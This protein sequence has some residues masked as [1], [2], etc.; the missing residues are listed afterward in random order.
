MGENTESVLK[1]FIP[2]IVK[3][4]GIFAIGAVVARLTGFLLRITIARGLGKSPYG[5]FSLGLSFLS[6]ASV[7]SV[8]GLRSG[9]KRYVSMFRGKENW[10]GVK[11]TLISSL[12]ISIPVALILAFVLFNT[13]SWVS[14]EIFHNRAFTPVLKVFSVSLPIAVFGHILASGLLGFRRMDYRIYS[15]TG[16]YLSRLALAGIAILW[17]YGIVVVSTSVILSAAVSSLIALYLLQKKLFPFI[18]SDRKDP[19]LGKEL[20]SYSLPLMVA[21]LLITLLGKI[22]TMMLG[23]LKNVA[24]V[25][26]YN[27]ALPTAILVPI[28]GLAGLFFPIISELYGRDEEEAI[29]ILSNFTTKWF[30]LIALPLTVVL[31]FFSGPI[32][33]ILFGREYVAASLS[34]K[35]LALGFLV[36]YLFVTSRRLVEMV[37]KTKVI[38]VANSTAAGTD[39]FLNYLL[40]PP[41]GIEGAAMATAISL[42]VG[43]LLA[44]VFTLKAVG[45]HPFSRNHLKVIS[46]CLGATLAFLLPLQV[47]V[48]GFSAIQFFACA[49]VFF[50]VYMLFL[51]IFGCFDRYDIILLESIESKLDWDLGFLKK[52]IK[53]LQ[54]I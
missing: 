48:S 21:A 46:A 24:K 9:V 26:L 47:F 43:S 14:T 6:L 11:G 18:G 7:F 49:S 53:R 38:L 23:F 29:K 52:A 32:L 10:E 12:K 5:L 16:G 25:G 2:K 31:V 41:F 36:S 40:I 17:G 51:I 45:F 22:D 8:L 20:L 27:A 34:L 39:I 3:G 42:S 30:F 1:R 28:G 54:V 19:F 13:S 50:L 15:R 44:G 35:I 4:A 33:M 37:G